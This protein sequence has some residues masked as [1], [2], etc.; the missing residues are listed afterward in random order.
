MKGAVSK[1]RLETSFMNWLALRTIQDL[2]VL[3]VVHIK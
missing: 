2:I 1:N 3:M